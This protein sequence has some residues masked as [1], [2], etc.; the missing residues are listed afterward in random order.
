MVNGFTFL[1]QLR[2]LLH[3]EF[4]QCEL[5]AKNI[6]Q[7]RDAIRRMAL[8]EFVSVNQS[9]VAL[10]ERLSGL[11]DEFDSVVRDLAAVCGVSETARTLTDVLQLTHSPQ[12]ADLIRQYEKLAERARAVKQDI[13]INQ[14]LVKNIQSILVRALE[15]HRQPSCADDLYSMSGGPNQSG[16]PAALIRRK[17]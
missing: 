5:L 12:M 4:A 8:H 10:L 14:L 15:A 2:D 11:K 16:T 1:D 9:R 7:E 17:G 13:A 6:L 3:C